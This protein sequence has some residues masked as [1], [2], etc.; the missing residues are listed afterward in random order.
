[1]NRLV[2]EHNIATVVEF[3]CGDGSQLTLANYPSYIGFDVSRDVISK[4]RRRFADDPSKE[5]RV[6][7]DASAD[8]VVA[9]MA[10]SLDVI[11]HLV[12]DATFDIY[13]RRLTRSARRFICIYSS[14][15]EQRTEAAHVRHRRFTTWLELNAPEWCQFDEIPN[16]FPY[17]P[18]RPDETSWSNFY[19]F[20]RDAE[21]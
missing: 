5:F 21:R 6:A 14:N 4:C 13:M 20:S 18:T 12:E 16:A 15:T 2:G 8:T 7:D 10:I 1:M 11:Y 3:G 19:I 17:D 9:D